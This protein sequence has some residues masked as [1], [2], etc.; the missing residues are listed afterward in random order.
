MFHVKGTGGVKAAK[1][2]WHGTFK[3]RETALW[4]ANKGPHG[5]W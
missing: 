5:Q 1:M 2:E 3:Q 4:L